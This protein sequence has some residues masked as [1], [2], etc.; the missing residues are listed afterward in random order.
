MLKN[1]TG[2]F[3]A[4]VIATGALLAGCG[5][6]G[7]EANQA[8]IAFA[9]E[10]IPHHEQA[11]EMAQL[12]PSRA[13]K[14]EVRELAEQIEAAQD[15]EIKTMTGWLKEWDAESSGMD[16]GDMGGDM[17]GMMTDTDMAELEKAKGAAFDR[18]FLE[19]MIKHHE[20]AIE[21]SETELKD[22]KHAAAK[23]L[24]QE[25]I[26]AQQAEIDTMNDLLGKS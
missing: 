10:M 13:E 12:A 7:D 15:P 25:I 11:I 18:M 3:I 26:D 22:G 23:A 21:M 4:V 16:H 17:P 1:R 24:A 19:M 5:D 14:Q 20:G 8:D 2:R 9:Q 6:N